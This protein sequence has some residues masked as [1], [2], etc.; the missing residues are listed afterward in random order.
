MHP[1][2]LLQSTIFC[3]AFDSEF[4]NKKDGADLKKTVMSHKKTYHKNSQYSKQR[5]LYFLWGFFLSSNVLGG[6][7]N[8]LISVWL[9]G[10]YT[11]KKTRDVASSTDT[12]TQSRTI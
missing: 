1:D 7:F 12:K 11:E 2:N 4:W 3:T 10:I 8:R 5:M 6:I 9:D